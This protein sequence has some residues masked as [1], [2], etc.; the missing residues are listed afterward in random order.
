M[1]IGAQ[2]NAYGHFYPIQIAQFGL[3]HLSKLTFERK[4]AKSASNSTVRHF[5][6]SGKDR[7]IHHEN[8][9]ASVTRFSNGFEF[10]FPGKLRA[11]AAPLVTA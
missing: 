8:Q 3:S 9:H 4:L 10:K 11:R 7:W 1:P 6:A 5:N 2:W